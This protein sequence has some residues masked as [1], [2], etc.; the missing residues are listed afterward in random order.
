MYHPS[1]SLVPAWL[2][3]CAAQVALL[4]PGIAGLIAGPLGGIVSDRF[5]AAHPGL[6]VARLIPNTFTLTAVGCAGLL[7][8]GWT[9]H[10]SPH[11]ALTLA[12][13][14]AACFGYT[15]YVPGLFSYITTIKQSAA[16]AASGGVQSMMT[17]MCGV[18]VLAGSFVIKHVG[19]GWWFTGLACV[20]LCV[21][22]VA[23]GIIVRKRRAAKGAAADMPA[24][25]ESV[26]I[27]C[28]DAAQAM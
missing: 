3:P 20:Q 4:S 6:P 14:C 19:Y 27:D 12:P 23:S 22:A 17:L 16:S 21:A 10:T 18:M 13:V 26:T 7:V 28:S 8:S 11:L 9:L 15:M 2:C 24:D 25:G 5:G 1:N